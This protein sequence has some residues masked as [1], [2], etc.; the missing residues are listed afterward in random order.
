MPRQP[1]DLIKGAAERTLRVKP[2]YSRFRPLTQRAKLVAKRKAAYEAVHPETKHGKDT[3]AKSGRSAR[4]IAPD[5]TRAQ[6][7]WP[8]SGPRRR[9]VA[10]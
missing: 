7:P 3:A 5:A 9:H 2:G 8:R 1:F 10:R 6:G 4:S